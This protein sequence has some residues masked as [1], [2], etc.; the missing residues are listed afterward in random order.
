MPELRLG[1]HDLNRFDLAL[2]T[3]NHSLA[4]EPRTQWRQANAG[5]LGYNA[6]NKI[7]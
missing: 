7:M 6:N 4:I 5:A 3:T 1:S 2:S